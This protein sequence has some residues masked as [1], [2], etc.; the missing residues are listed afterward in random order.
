VRAYAVSVLDDGSNGMRQRDS[1]VLA[2]LLL[3]NPENFG[4]GHAARPN[5]A[6]RN[7]EESSQTFGQLFESVPASLDP[8]GDP[9]I[10][11]RPAP[12]SPL[13]SGGLSAFTGTLADRAGS[14]VV[15]TSY[16]GAAAPG[17]PAWWD[18]WTVYYVQ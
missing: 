9:R 18:G 10:N 16:R 11:W 6:G 15:P 3:A 14:F 7:L 12:G 13:A 17:G 5:W 2:N 8:A 1:L 4:P